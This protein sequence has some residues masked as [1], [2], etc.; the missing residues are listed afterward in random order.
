MIANKLA[1]LKSKVNML[2]EKVQNGDNSETEWLWNNLLTFQLD[3][4]NTE[5]PERF[6]ITIP[7]RVQNIES[8]ISGGAEKKGT[9]RI[10]HLT[11]SKPLNDYPITNFPSFKYLVNLKEVN[12]NFDTSKVTRIAFGGGNYARVLERINGLLDFS[13]VGT[14]ASLNINNLFAYLVNLRE[15]RFAQGGLNQSVNF[16][17]ALLSDETIQSIINGLVQTGTVLTL[18]LHETVKSKLTEEQIAN[19]NEKGWTLA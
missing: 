5:Y 6:E 14:T 15:V 18:T 8:I 17:S 12:I 9:N 19:I 10:V 1:L 2:I 11:I 7:E 4:V 3:P 13:S 16:V